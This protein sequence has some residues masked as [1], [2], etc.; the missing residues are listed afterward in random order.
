[1]VFSTRPGPFSTDIDFDKSKK[2]HKN[3]AVVWPRA[4]S[5]TWD[6]ARQGPDSEGRSLIGYNFLN[7][8]LC[9]PTPEAR[10]EDIE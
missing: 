6:A 1:L 8:Y 4:A 3:A 5:R 7:F 9:E 10:S 2:K